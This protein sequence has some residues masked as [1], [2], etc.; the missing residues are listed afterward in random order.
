LHSNRYGFQTNPDYKD[1][2]F[3]FFS[4]RVEKKGMS[5]YSSYKQAHK[6]F[7]DFAEVDI[8]FAEITE[9][10]CEKFLQYL[11]TKITPKGTVLSKSTFNHYFHFFSATIFQA[12]KEKIIT[13]N[14]L[15]LMERLK[16]EEPEIVFL[17]LDEL[18]QLVK[19]E[20]KY[21]ELRRAF[22]FSCLTG[23]R[24]S[25]VYK[26]KWSEIQENQGKFSIIY[27]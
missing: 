10:F 23:L 15:L 7:K 12:M 4:N 25:D 5:I 11:K 9:G 1:S 2:N 14:P 24:W 21:T 20:I 17:T 8:T 26:L 3:Y 22:I 13:E 6:S 19:I 18:K 27:R 16:V